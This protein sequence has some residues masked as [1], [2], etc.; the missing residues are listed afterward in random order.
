MRDA[1][2]PDD[3]AT[4]QT[5]FR[6]Y[7]DWLGVDLC[8]QGFDEELASLPGKYAP[9]EGCLLLATDGDTVLGCC[10][11]RRF[12]PDVCEVKRLWVRPEAR[13]RGL[14]RELMARIE[15]HARLAGYNSA[16]LDTLETMEPAVRLYESLGYRRT[17]PYYHNPIPGAV[18]FR[19]SLA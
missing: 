19:K 10:A 18:Y 16:V 1:R 5:L 6:E 2:F 14:G 11:I 13:G 7:A 17:P 3:T 8:F 4:V 9:P 15:E 12:A